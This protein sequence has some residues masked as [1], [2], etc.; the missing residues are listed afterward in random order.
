[1]SLRD[2]NNIA[3]PLS[4]PIAREVEAIWNHSK[5]SPWAMEWICG[6]KPVGQDEHGLIYE[7]S[8]SDCVQEFET[9]ADAI[10]G[11]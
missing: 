1:M 8:E 10:E 3:K 9:M 6:V 7:F 4:N 2:L 11:N 5:P